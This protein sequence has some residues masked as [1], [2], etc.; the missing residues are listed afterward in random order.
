MTWFFEIINFDINLQAIDFLQ[1]LLRQIFHF[2]N[3]EKHCDLLSNNEKWI[4]GQ[5]DIETIKFLNKKSLP[6]DRKSFIKTWNRFNFQN[7]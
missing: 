5:E 4:Y 1:F 3:L 7:L 2:L 6:G